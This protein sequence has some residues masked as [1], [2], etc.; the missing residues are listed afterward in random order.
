MKVTFTHS[1]MEAFAMGYYHARTS[2]D[3]QND[4]MTPL[5]IWSYHRGYDTGTQALKVKTKE[6]EA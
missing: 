4:Y 5:E 6:H 1:Q 3:E 2:Q